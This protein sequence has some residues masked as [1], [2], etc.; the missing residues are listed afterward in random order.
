MGMRSA[1]WTE[2]GHQYYAFCSRI[3]SEIGA[4][5]EMIAGRTKAIEGPLAII[6]PKWIGNVDLADAIAR[7]RGAG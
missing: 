1:S 6:A 3:L 7:D 5:E 4:A 2:A